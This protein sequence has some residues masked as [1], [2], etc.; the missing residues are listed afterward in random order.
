MLAACLLPSSHQSPPTK[1]AKCMQNMQLP[2][3]Q[4]PAS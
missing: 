1:Q 3:N 2:T 4:L